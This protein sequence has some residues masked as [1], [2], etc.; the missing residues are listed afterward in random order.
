MHLLAVCRLLALPVLGFPA[1]A[2]AVRLNGPL[3]REFAGSVGAPQVGADGERL[4]Y[5][6]DPDG[7]GLAVL[8]SAEIGD[9][10]RVRELRGPGPLGERFQ[11]TPDG[12]HVLFLDDLDGGGGRELVVRPIDASRPA[13][14]VSAPLA[15]GRSVEWFAA[16][17]D[18]RHVLY[19]A[20]QAAHDVF[21]LFGA[22]LHGATPERLSGPLVPGGDVHAV[23]LSHDGLLA[24]YSAD[25]DQDEVVEL[26][27][28]PLDGSRPARKLPIP[29]APGGDVGPA[30]PWSLRFDAGAAHVL[31]V[32]DQVEDGRVELFS[33]ATDGGQAPRRLNGP[34]SAGG[35]VGS[36]TLPGFEFVLAADGRRV[37]YSADQEEDER[38]DLF[39]V[40]SDG[41]SPPV[42]LNAESHREV[43]FFDLG[44]DAAWLVYQATPDGANRRALFTV[45]PDGSGP[46]RSVSGPMV[47]GGSTR[48]AEFSPDG[49]RVLW[50]A[51][52]DADEVYE[53]YSARSDGS[54][55]P[56]K[57]NPPLAPDGDVLDFQVSREG[58]LYVADQEEDELF[59]LHRVGL[60]GAQPALIV[61]GPT[62]LLRPDASLPE[63]ARALVQ[64][65]REL[66]LV[67]VDPRLQPETLEHLPL[68]VVGD[69][70]DF[71]L[72]P[73]GGRTTYLAREEGDAYPALYSVR[74]SERPER[75]RLS[76]A[77][78][79]ARVLS[80]ILTADGA[81]VVFEASLEEGGGYGLYNSSVDGRGP[82]LEF[83]APPAGVILSTEPRLV[84]TLDGRRVVFVDFDRNGELRSALVDGSAPPVRLSAA[85]EVVRGGMKV[86]A[87]GSRVAYRT[88]ADRRLFTVAADGSAPG[89]RASGDL[90]VLDD[91][92]LD[93]AGRWVAF[94]ADAAKTELYVAPADGSAPPRRLNGIL[95]AGREVVAFALAPDGTRAVYL[96]DEAADETFELF[97][98]PLDGSA[99]AVRLHPPL[100]PGRDVLDFQITSDSLRVVYRADA[101]ADE[102]LELFGVPADA[103]LP[104]IRLSGALAA[105]G[106]VLE[107]RLSP[108]GRRVVYRADQRT[109]G[110]VELFSAAT[111]G[112]RATIRLSRALVS[113]GD[114]RSFEISADSSTVAFAAERDARGACTLLLAPITGREKAVEVAGPFAGSGSIFD[115]QLAPDGASVAYRADQD[116]PGVLELYLVLRGGGALGRG[117]RPTR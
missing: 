34:L 106:D 116:T 60:D 36:R 56:V 67:A 73:S 40:P 47:A 59:E 78:P 23:T 2:Q 61:P 91:F 48:W 81:H 38:F 69:V 49:T 57:L 83:A 20:D 14:A 66:V 21:E 58:V 11:I 53:L 76:P 68:A 115:Y 108:D 1:A 39:G 114:V 18:G 46:P 45:P 109:D 80:Q 15:A 16:S 71:D 28:V 35:D 8:H 90:P 24:A 107:Y 41:S 9:G 26:F 82:L 62:Q 86:S 112:S 3:A 101:L 99:A 10:G 88:N 7:S 32:A 65:P 104:P 97:G 51:D 110:H 44:R 87:D 113:G 105:G 85:G 54:A 70:L 42:R 55:P 111:R 93:A 79:R 5:L 43:Q 13:V 103:G 102:V 84:L 74:A 30:F 37:V 4:V 52:Q 117:A 33:V 89:E 19:L 100:A 96:A 72:G 64:R 31:Y 94:R 29:L 77:L 92:A 98:V 50:V 12:K 6:V 95:L 22:E 17:A 27:V 25:Q 63:P 75:V